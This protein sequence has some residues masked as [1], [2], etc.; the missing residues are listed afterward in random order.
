MAQMDEI[1]VLWL[2]LSVNSTILV[3]PVI[4]PSMIE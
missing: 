2:V 1:Q 3:Y 4:L